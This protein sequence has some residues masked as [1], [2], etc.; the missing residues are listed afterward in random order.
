MNTTES[1]LTLAT[2]NGKKKK[3]KVNHSAITMKKNSRL[4]IDLAPDVLYAG[5]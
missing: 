5:L 4:S 2:R 1:H 3:K